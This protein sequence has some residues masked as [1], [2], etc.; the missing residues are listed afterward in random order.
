[1]SLHTCTSLTQLLALLFRTKIDPSDR[2]IIIGR[3]GMGLTLVFATPIVLLPCREAILSL[4]TKGE[5]D[6]TSVV[7]SCEMQLESNDILDEEKLLLRSDEVEP[8]FSVVD[9]S[10]EDGEIES[11]I[12][13]INDDNTVLYSSSF[14]IASLAYIGAVAVPGVET[15]WSVI[16]SSLGIS[17]AFIIPSLCYLTIRRKKGMKRS[18][19]LWSLLLLLFSIFAAI[20]CTIMSV[21]SA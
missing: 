9:K 16:G 10:L 18:S 20:V 13:N 7:K 4:V 17:I 19:S 3:L 21:W 2:L 8:Y 11:E 15:V 5:C 14:S 1:M 12:E 6:S